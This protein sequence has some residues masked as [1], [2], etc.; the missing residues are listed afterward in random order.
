MTG[1]ILGAQGEDTGPKYLNTP[2]TPLFDKG[3]TL[4]LIDKAKSAIR[5]SG[6]AVLVEGNTDALMAHQAG[7]TN[8]VCSMGTALTAGQV[9]LLTRYAPR[10]A[11][12]YDVDAAG[13]GAAAFGATELTAL[14]GEIERSPYRGRLTD[15]DVVRLPDGRDPTRSS[16]TI[17]RPGV[18][19]PSTPSP[20]WSSSSTGPHLVSIPARSPVGRSWSP[21]C[22]RRSEPSA[23]RCA[24]TAICNCWP[25]ARAS[26]SER[27]W[28]RCDAAMSQRPVV[29]GRRRQVGARI[30]LEAVMTQP[31]ALDP[32]AV[33]RAI[34]PAEAVRAAADAALPAPLPRHRAGSRWRPLRDPARS[35]AVEGVGRARS[36]SRAPTTSTA[37]PSSA[38]STRPS[39]PWR[40][41]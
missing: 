29:P 9:E 21:P 30:N 35:R 36:R 7:F 20:S 25:A 3:R 17:P 26:R 28:R 10:I 32:R 2:Q 19:P 4:F 38:R 24:A 6:V 39:R 22:S 14:V 8:V 12:A 16:A 1:R 15:V 40:R 13:Q 18:R 23:I 34:E 41:P 37:R 11:L 27:C 31:D 33:E 5:K